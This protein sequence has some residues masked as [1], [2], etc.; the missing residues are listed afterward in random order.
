MEVRNQYDHRDL[1]VRTLNVDRVSNA[2]HSLQSL[3]SRIKLNNLAALRYSVISLIRWQWKF[4]YYLHIVSLLS[5]LQSFISSTSINSLLY[6]SITK[7]SYV[8]L[9]F[10]NKMT[11][12]PNHYLSDLYTT[13][14]RKHNTRRMEKCPTC[15]G[16][17]KVLAGEQR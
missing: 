10:I 17:G 5:S 3:S 13:D 14:Q 2:R 11:E 8:I 6:L 9:D 7:N 1:K 4:N 12:D 15:N 16:S